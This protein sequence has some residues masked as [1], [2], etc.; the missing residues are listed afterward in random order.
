MLY[1]AEK[2]LANEVLPGSGELLPEVEWEVDGTRKQEP[3]TGY[4]SDYPEVR[5]GDEPDYFD[6][7]MRFGI[8]CVPDDT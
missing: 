1:E 5:N 8:K 7:A 4:R 3:L 2:A 6:V